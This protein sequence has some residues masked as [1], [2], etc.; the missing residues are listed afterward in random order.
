M[1]K[2]IFFLALCT[3]ISNDIFGQF[4]GRTQSVTN[5]PG[6]FLI[7]VAHIR[8]KDVDKSVLEEMY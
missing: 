1:K 4:G 7:P 8:L 3:L 5:R 6:N 2:L